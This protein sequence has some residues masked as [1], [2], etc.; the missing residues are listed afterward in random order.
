MFSQVFSIFTGEVLTTSTGNLYLNSLIVKKYIQCVQIKFCF[1]LCPLTL[2]LSV[3]TTEKSLVP[4][5]SFPPIRYL[6]TLIR[7]HWPFSSPESQLSKRLLICWLTDQFTVHQ[8]VKV[9]LKRA[10]FQ[11]LS[12]WH[13]LVHDLIPAPG[14]GLCTS[15]CGTS[16]DSPLLNSPVCPGHCEWWHIHLAYE[17]LLP[18]LHQWQTH[19]GYKMCHCPVN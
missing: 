6:Y 14:A 19:R 4:F 10:A 18:V 17:P 7:Y 8:D 9:P 2:A 12:P 3:S 5:S 16:W 1:N 15:S 13:V 11:P